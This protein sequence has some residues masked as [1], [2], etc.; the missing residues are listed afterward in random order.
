[1]PAAD[2]ALIKWKARSGSPQAAARRTRVVKVVSLGVTPS[3][4]I[5]RKM[6]M[7]RFAS[8]GVAEGCEQR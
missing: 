8:E 1:M 7:A 6:S 2:M 4:D 3:I 5:W